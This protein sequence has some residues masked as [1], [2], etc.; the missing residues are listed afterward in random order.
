MISQEKL[1]EIVA[2]KDTQALTFTNAVQM[3]EEL[4]RRQAEKSPPK[5]LSAQE[6][7]ETGAYWWCRPGVGNRVLVLVYRPDG[8][9]L[10]MRFFLNGSDLLLN[11]QF[12]GPIQ[13]P[14]V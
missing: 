4:Y 6:V 9:A 5:V 10:R 8:C 13:M 2:K 11:G 14:E 12:I 3:A 1:N 7:K